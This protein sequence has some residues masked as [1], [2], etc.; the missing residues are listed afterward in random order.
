MEGLKGG[1]VLL[2]G[3]NPPDETDAA[4]RAGNENGGVRADRERPDR[5]RKVERMRRKKKKTLSSIESKI[6]IVDQ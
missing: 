2:A 5:L 4:V 6:Q 3:K 1:G